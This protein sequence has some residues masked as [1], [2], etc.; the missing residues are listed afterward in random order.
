MSKVPTKL[1]QLRL[2]QADKLVAVHAAVV[3]K[4]F[5]L[6]DIDLRCE[7]VAR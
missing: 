4:S 5:V 3:S 6:S 7:S 1:S 2:P